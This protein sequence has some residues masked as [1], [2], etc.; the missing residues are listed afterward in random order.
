[1]QAGAVVDLPAKWAKELLSLN[2]GTGEVIEALTKVHKRL[3]WFFE[4]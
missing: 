1:M 3:Y 2:I 4:Y